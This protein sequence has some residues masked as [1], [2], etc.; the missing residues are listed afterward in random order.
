MNM[1][2][3]SQTEK[4]LSFFRMLGSLCLEVLMKTVILVVSTIE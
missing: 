1:Y 3:Y 2:S 4:M